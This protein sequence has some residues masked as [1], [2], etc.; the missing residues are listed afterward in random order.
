[1]QSLAGRSTTANTDLIFLKNGTPVQDVVINLN[2]NG[3]TFNSLKDGS[4]L[5]TAGSDYTLSG[6]TLTIKAHALSKYATGA[7]G[8]KAVFTVNVSSGPAWKLHVRYI[9]TPAFS[10]TTAVTGGA[11]VI[12]LAYHGDLLANME[13][14]N[15]DGSNPGSASWTSFQMFGDNYVPDYVNNTLT[16]TNNFVQTLPAG[17]VTLAVRFWSGKI[18]TYKLQV[19]ARSAGSGTEYSIYGDALQAGWNDWSSWTTH[20]LSDTTQVHSGSNALSITF[21]QWGGVGLQ[22]GGT[23]ID[24][25]SYHTLVFW[26]HGGTT[27]GQKIGITP[28]R[29]G[30]WASSGIQMPAPAANTWQKVEIPLTSFGIDGASDISGFLF[31]DWSGGDQATIYLDDIALSTA[32]STSVMDIAGSVPTAPLSITKG[33]FTLNRR[34]NRMVQ[35][36]TV[37]N[38]SG[39][40]VTGPI[41]LVLDSLSANTT[42]ANAGGTTG[43]AV[44]SGSPY[45][46]VTAGTLAPQASVTVTLEFTVPTS[47]GITYDA[48]TVS[49][50]N[51]P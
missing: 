8:E 50:G 44:P 22:N 14:K 37:R 6:S 1:M 9:D 41:Y 39:S 35:T 30:T 31:Q 15:A 24:T 36:V 33:G 17:T 28:A 42:L 46:Q 45:R 5:L 2:L 34:T 25:S 4:T 26:V 47:G 43:L 51:A 21:S 16:L 7:Y 11:V 18:L 23:A 38:T 49:G 13:A 29:S 20:N 12:P 10:N 19:T 40:T 48:R 32:Q 27:G 3:N